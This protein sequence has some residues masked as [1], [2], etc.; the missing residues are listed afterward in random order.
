MEGT[1]LDVNYVVTGD[2]SVFARWRVSPKVILITSTKLTVLFAVALVFG[3]LLCGAQC[4][5][6]PVSESSQNMPPCHQHHSD[7]GKNNSSAPCSHEVLIS[8][9][10]DQG[11]VQT[12]IAFPTEALPLAE[13]TQHNLIP[14]IP[15]VGNALAVSIL[16]PTPPGL[17]QF[18]ILRV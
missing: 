4:I 17:P 6:N 18:T 12:S 11:T 14:G 3:Q 13:F 8:A 15:I 16:L 10:I 5:V 9:A 7:S 2:K 1:P